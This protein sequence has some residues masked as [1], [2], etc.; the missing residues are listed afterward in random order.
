MV[1]EGG[2]IAVDGARHARDDRA[3]PP[4][5]EPQSRAGAGPTS[6]TRCGRALGVDRV[7]WLADAI[8]EDD[9]TDGHVDNVVAFTPR[10]RACCCRVA[11]IPR[12]RTPR[13]RPTT[14]ARLARPG[15]T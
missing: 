8:A 15:S 3:L 4:Q 11:T 5:P 7:V 12:T 1:L 2:S 13:S 6:R 9:G 10:R 14:R